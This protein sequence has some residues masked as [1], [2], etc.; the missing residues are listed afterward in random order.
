MSF[1]Q[2][3]QAD[4][5]T[6]GLQTSS[7][8]G[9]SGLTVSEIRGV[10]PHR[11][12]SVEGAVVAGGASLSESHEAWVVPARKPP[13]YAVRIVGP[14]GFYREVRFTG[15]ETDAEIEQSVRNALET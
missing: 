7:G 12:E 5:V 9:L 6:P 15:P 2:W 1:G 11:R 4:T 10:P 13:G 3:N 14:R 8:R